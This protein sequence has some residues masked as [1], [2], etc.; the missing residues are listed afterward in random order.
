MLAHSLTYWD[1]LALAVLPFYLRAIV[2]AVAA[3]IKARRRV[4]RPTEESRDDRTA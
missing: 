3:I 2:L 1:G 4:D